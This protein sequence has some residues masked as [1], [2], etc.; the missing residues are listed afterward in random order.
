MADSGRCTLA[1]RPSPRAARRGAPRHGQAPAEVR[2]LLRRSRC[3][4]SNAACAST[5]RARPTARRARPRLDALATAA[6]GRSR[7]RRPAHAT[8][9]AAS[10]SSSGTATSSA[11]A[12]CRRMSA[13]SPTAALSDA[14]LLRR[15]STSSTIDPGEDAEAVAARAAAGA[16][17]SSTRRPRTAMH[18][19][20]RARTIRSTRSCS[21]TC[22]S[23]TWSA[24]GTSSRRP[25]RPS[26]SPCST[27]A[28]RT[29]TPP[30]SSTPTRSS[31]TRGTLYPALGDI[32]LPFVAATELAST[33]RFVAPHDFIWDDDTAARPRRPRHARQRHDRPADQQR[34]RHRRRR[35]QRQAHAGQGHQQRRGT[36]SSAR[37]TSGTDD[38]V[39]RGIRYAADNGAKVINMSIGR[40]G[41]PAPVVEDA[42]KYAVGKGAFV[43]IAGGQRFRR[44]QPD[45]SRSPR[46]PRA[47]RAPCRSRPSI[48][49]RTHAY[50]SSSGS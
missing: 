47:S 8:R 37:R 46:S 20:V 19:A 9:P 50:Y 32:T 1:H 24:P 6:A 49:P 35:V 4:R 28:S 23:S 17:T 48:A 36:T 41:P 39:A 38:V 2:A 16:P 10:S 43:A 26:P 22:R 12:R 40:S 30:C 25:A 7:R 29:R 21:G 45:R 33:G 11:A 34:R 31:T 15:T 44:R 27:P 3:R 13:A 18:A 14:P 42:I 5:S